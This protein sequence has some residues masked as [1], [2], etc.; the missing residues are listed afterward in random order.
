MMP[1]GMSVSFRCWATSTW[2]IFIISLLFFDAWQ[3]STWLSWIHFQLQVIQFLFKKIRS[4]LW[5]NQWIP[6]GL[7]FPQGNPLFLLRYQPAGCFILHFFFLHQG[8]VDQRSL[9]LL[10]LQ[11]L[12]LLIKVMNDLRVASCYRYLIC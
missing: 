1:L 10:L 8:F 7:P 4:E 9:F 6:I 5:Y 11:L 3:N 12:S 2:R